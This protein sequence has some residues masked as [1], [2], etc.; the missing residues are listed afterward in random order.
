MARRPVAEP[1]EVPGEVTAR[2][3]IVNQGGLFSPYYLF[4]V[5]ARLHREELDEGEVAA[6]AREVRRLHRQAARRLAA[7]SSRA[8]VWW[9][10]HQPLLSSLGFAPEPLEEPVETAA[11]AVPVGRFQPDAE[12]RPLVLIDL[13]AMGVDLDRDRYAGAVGAGRRDDPPLSTQPIALAFEAALDAHAEARWGLLGNGAELRLYRKGSPVSRQYLAAN[14]PALVEGDRREEWT[15]LYACFRAAAFL[16]GPDGRCFLDQVLQESEQHAGRIADDLRANVQE[17]VEALVGGVIAERENWRLWGG[18]APD[19]EL[20]RRLFQEALYVLYRLL[21]IAFAEAHGL[22]PAA[23][24]PVYRDAYS[25]EHLRDLCDRPLPDQEGDRDY[26]WRTVQTLFRLVREGFGEE[27]EGVLRIPPI[28]G[29]LFS[30]GRTPILSR[31]RVADRALHRVVQALSLERSGRRGAPSRFSYLDLGV[32]QLGSIYEGLLSYEADV[33]AEPMVEARLTRDGKPKGELLVLPQRLVETSHRLAAATDRV[34]PAGRFLLRAGGVRRKASG[35]YYTPSPLASV[36]VEKALEPLVAPIVEGCGRRDARGRPVRRPEEVLEITVID[37]A[38][39]SGAF[40]VHAVRLLADAYRRA[41]QAA[42]AP[43]ERLRPQELA[44]VKRLIAQRCVYGIDLN[45]MAVELA[46]VSLWLETL[47]EGEPLSFLDAHLRCGDSLVGAP[48]AVAGDG[49]RL[50][51]LPDA[52]YAAVRKEASKEWR[53]ALRQAR[54]RNAAE[55]RRLE[56][57]SLFTETLG[58][59]LTEGLDRLRRVREEIAAATPDPEAPLALKQRAEREKA[60]RYA[61]AR[62]EPLVRALEEIANLWCAVWFWPEDPSCPPPDTFRYRTVA[63][64]LL[65][66]AREGR[67]PRLAG[68]EAVQLEVARRVAAERRFFHRWLE[69]PE[70]EAAGGYAAVVGN[71][72]WETVNTDRKEFLAPFDAE[73]IALE[74]PALDRG[75][76]RLFQRDPEAAGAWAQ[77]ERLRLQQAQFL[78][79]SGLYEWQSKAGG[80]L[81]TYQLFF[82]R[83]A[84]EL[85]PGGQCA[86]VLSGAFALK[87]NAAELRRRTFDGHRLRFLV[88]SDNERRVY[89]ISDRVEFCLVQVGRERPTG[90][91]P[92]AFLVGKR[93]DGSWRSLELAGLVELVRGLP[94]G[95]VTVDR[96]LLAQLSPETL[97]P[98]LLNHPLDAELLVRIFR[99]FSRLGDPASGWRAVFGREIDS[100]ADRGRFVARS[101]LEARGA[102]RVSPIEYRLGEERYLPLLEGRNVWQL[103]YGFTEPKLWIS[104][105]DAEALLPPNPELGGLR[106]NATLRVVWRDV[107]QMK[108]ERTM[109]A[110]IAPAGTASKDSLPYVRAGSLSPAEMVLLAAL[111]AGFVFD[112]QLRAQGI[113]R[114]K[115]GPLRTQPVPSPSE[116]AP[117]LPLAL[118]ALEP[119]WLR[120]EAAREC[121]A[122]PAPVEWW[123]ARAR[124]DAALFERYGL[125]LEEVAHVLAAFPLLDRQQPPLPG[126]ARSTVTRDLVL[127]ETALGYEQPD[128]EP[129]RLFGPGAGRGRARERAEAALRLGAV[130]YVAAPQVDQ[131]REWV[132]DEE[133]E[134]E[135]EEG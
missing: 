107:S 8:E 100:S 41:L 26:L 53:E 30:E 6:L 58:R 102:R 19:R 17:A 92:C 83:G 69:F 29:E 35:S 57:G 117:L 67:E 48:E 126:E 71:P 9:Y 63:E 52:A 70:V 31:A 60:E 124:L 24:D 21:F 22:L 132:E 44:A 94:R 78:A 7:D 73:L 20:A 55:L 114:M 86:L 97:T 99:R 120:D 108:N 122:A 134:E 46:K 72:P 119:G 27:G 15:A 3:G 4:D 42:G 12:G 87:A 127:A 106:S 118:A 81:N 125:S 121:G 11:G 84:R 129:A 43:E 98:P 91:L 45:P 64:E 79:A 109:V 18:H 135:G 2:R 77:E 59:A 34:I 38:M 25:F 50:D 32:D 93:E 123:R 76:E 80:Y 133:D 88:L 104:A 111:W 85:R 113:N 56:A 96:E 103:R 68:P 40:L 116:L 23:D 36:L 112:W 95:A 115:F 65:A 5:M 89:P 105:R 128:P 37:Q 110:A 13:H 33:T 49:P 54:R 66:A 47:A 39:G 101:R 90:G 51:R 14:L 130:P 61:Q 75:I 28:G 16:P 62:A 131:S 1:E 82:E 10:W 74:G